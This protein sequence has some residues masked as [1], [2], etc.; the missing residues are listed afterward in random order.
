[1]PTAKMDAASI[2]HYE[3]LARANGGSVGASMA[4]AQRAADEPKAAKQAKGQKTTVIEPMVWKAFG[5]SQP[6]AEYRFAPPRRWRFDYAW[7]EQKI[8]LEIDGGAGFGRHT[9]R[10]GFIKDQGKRNAAVMRGWGVIHCIPKDVKD[11]SI[12][13]A[14]RQAL[15]IEASK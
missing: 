12:F 1:M 15:A 4:D 3:A 11:G 14:I 6:T 10:E 13:K 9:R 5:I 7:I 2:A 8:A